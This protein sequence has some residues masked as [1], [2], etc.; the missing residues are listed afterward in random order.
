MQVSYLGGPT[1]RAPAGLS[2]LE[3][4]RV[5]EV[6]HASLCGG[7]GR[8]GAC[9]VRV[10]DGERWLAPPGPVE[11]ETR[12]RLGL[13]DGVR[14]ACQCVP[15][16]SPLTIERLADPF[17]APTSLRLD[18]AE[19]GR[20]LDA[21]VVAARVRG[22]ERQAA[23][24]PVHDVL[25][26]LERRLGA[27]RD[28]L[29]GAG[30][31][32]TPVA[33]EGLVAVLPGHVRAACSAQAVLDAVAPLVARKP[34]SHAAA[35]GLEVRVVLHRGPVLV[36]DTPGGDP[37]LAGSTVDGALGLLAADLPADALVVSTAVGEGLVL[38]P[39]AAVVAPGGPDG[40]GVT[41]TPE[42]AEA[43]AR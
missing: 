31:R 9:R 2:L 6:P 38:P 33:G 39:G 42:L 34:D 19:G 35:D 40:S 24:H 16:G 12:D 21:V 23:S 3:V 13:D 22:A 5:C 43:V 14:L 36:S 8:C 15:T 41:S 29:E 25:L 20:R 17:E 10:V 37:V 28:A 11:R 27:L 1:V 7:R 18:L 26:A 4:S 30:A 32:V